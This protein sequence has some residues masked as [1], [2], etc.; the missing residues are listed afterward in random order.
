MGPSTG[1]GPE[2]GRARLLAPGVL[3]KIETL[4][5]FSPKRFRGAPRGDRRSPA[6]RRGPEVDDHPPYQLGAPHPPR[7]SAEPRRRGRPPRVSGTTRALR[8]NASGAGDAAAPGH[9]PPPGAARPVVGPVRSP[10][11]RAGAAAL[12]AS[13]AADVFDSR[14]G[15]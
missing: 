6:R 11:V 7:P 13:P 12:P 15:R 2:A 5:L 8:R 4:S 14:A 9:G 3:P 1:L 10:G